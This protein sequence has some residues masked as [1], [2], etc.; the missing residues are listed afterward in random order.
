MELQGKL[1]GGFLQDFF[2][3]TFENTYL[4]NNGNLKF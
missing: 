2:I 4:K 1:L 3:L